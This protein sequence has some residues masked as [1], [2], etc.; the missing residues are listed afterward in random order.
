LTAGWAVGG[1]PTSNSP[2][3]RAA[4]GA[5]G[6]AHTTE[7][8]VVNVLFADL[9]GFTTISATRDP[10]TIR[11]LQS[12]YFERT[13]EIVGR[14]GG[15]VEKFIG[16]AVM[17]LW[18]APT[19]HEDDA[20]R[21]VRA[22]LDLVEMV[23]VIGREMNI[24]LQLRAGVLTGEAAV[25]VGSE[26]E[27][28]VTGDMVNTAAR[29]QSV[30]QPGTVLVGE[31]TRLAAGDAITFEAAG[32][33]MLKGKEAP[34]AAWRAMRV[35]AERGGARRPAAGRGVE[36]GHRAAASGASQDR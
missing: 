5:T 19:A 8:R 32:E 25:Q 20:E 6:A 2:A 35:V 14:Y 31:A 28:M 12:R 9:V 33:Q 13:R 29:L 11:E 17:A 4:G 15:V 22:A 16:D 36:R 7:R 21:A 3:T 24:D 23:P 30:A 1:P 27:G 34:V 26:A 18:G 10:E